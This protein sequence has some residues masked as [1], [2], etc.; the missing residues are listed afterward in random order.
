MLPHDLSQFSIPVREVRWKM[1]RDG[2]YYRCT[3]VKHKGG[4]EQVENTDPQR[5]RELGS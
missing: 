1:V 3:V 2:V 4:K 5:G